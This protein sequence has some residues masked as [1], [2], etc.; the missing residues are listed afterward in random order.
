MKYYIVL[1]IS[2]VAFGL[3]DV[4]SVTKRMFFKVSSVDAG[5]S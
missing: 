1:I 2:A 3:F 4:A 5:G